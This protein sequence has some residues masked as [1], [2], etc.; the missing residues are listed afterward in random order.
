MAQ[1]KVKLI[2]DGVIDVNH[3][4]SGHSITTDNIGEGSNL[5][6]TDARVST[7]L[8]TNNYATEG[9]V[10]TNYLA[11][12]GGALTG[13]LEINRSGSY[14]TGTDRF[15]IT[16]S[17]NTRYKGFLRLQTPAGEPVLSLGTYNDPTTYDTLFLRKG[18]I[19]IGTDNP[20]T[21]L[22]SIRG[23]G[24][25]DSNANQGLTLESNH[26]YDSGSKYR[27]NGYASIISQDTGGSLAGYIRFQQAG[28]NSSGAGAAM[29][30]S[31][32]MVIDES[33]N[34][35]INTTSPDR[36]LTLNG[37]MSVPFSFTQSVFNGGYSRNAI[38]STGYN[39]ASDFKDFLVLQAP[40]SSSSKL[41][42]KGSNDNRVGV[43]TNSPENALHVYN[44]EAKDPIRVESTQTFST[45][46][47]KSSTNSQTGVFGVD[48]A[49]QAYIENKKTDSPIYFATNLTPR[50]YIKGDG[51]VG[52]GTTSPAYRLDVSGDTR[53]L[54][55]LI[56]QTDG[57]NEQ[58]K[59]ARASNGSEQLIIGYH[60]SDYAQIQAVEQNVGYRPLALNPNGGNVGIGTTTPSAKLE[61]NGYTAVGTYSAPHYS[62]SGMAYQIIKATGGSDAQRAMLEVHSGGGGTKGIFQSVG[63]NNTVYSGTLTNSNF[64]IGND[65]VN[66]YFNTGGLIGI[67]TT[68][69]FNFGS[70]SA[71]IDLRSK[72]TTSV[73]GIFIGNSDGSARLVSYFN[74]GAS[75]FVGTT[76][77]HDLDLGTSDVSR[78]RIKSNGDVGI[79][80]TSPS[81]K[82]DVNGSHRFRGDNYNEYTWKGS[83]NYTSGTFYD[84]MNSQQGLN[85]GIYVITCYINTYAAGSGV[86]YMYFASVPFYWVNTGTN[87]PSYQDLPTLLGTGHARNNV[88]PPTFRLQQ[89]YS[90]SDGKMYLQFNPNANW[91]GLDE[92]VDGRQFFV[93]LKRIGG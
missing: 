45:I 16:H 86:Y 27:N 18:N 61:V 89:S 22:L 64:S 67:N 79:A 63:G 52:I 71:M 13:T 12:S 23:Y 15:L 84:V 93:Y 47:F 75:G 3:L 31:D 68:S 5:Y 62:Q 1:T 8:S 40:G 92:N 35:G 24:A 69:P 46:A 60:S 7:Y 48:G 26:Y 53:L 74:P 38:F 85:S 66:M 41:I 51:S 78:I 87:N 59:I 10:N 90:A 91:S 80:T 44:T 21:N 50:L 39:N 33:G 81:A 6:Y 76:S 57:G 20:G 43:N 72:T 73:S 36:L 29:T 55:N 2:S 77:A 28:L 83:G 54:G 19:G 25:I 9:W 82:L 11:L 49:G 34:V 56:V 17:E 58:I 4:A 30:L 32:S 14:D 65:V 70:N 88:T 37:N 42:L